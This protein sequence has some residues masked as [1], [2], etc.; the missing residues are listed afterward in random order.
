MLGRR[1][2]YRGS[3]NGAVALVRTADA[4]PWSEDDAALL[5]AVADQLGIALRQIADQRTLERLSRTDDLSG[6]LNR[7]AF[8]EDL[9]QAL[10]RA[11]RERTGGALLYVDLDNFKPIND[12]FGHARGDA[13]L[14]AVAKALRASCRAYDLAARL[15]GDEFAV[16]LGGVDAAGARRRATELLAR[17][18]DLASDAHCED[19]PLSLSI[20]V[21]TVAPGTDETAEQLIRR[22]DAAMYVGK[23]AGKNRYAEAAV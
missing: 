9:A 5:D 11:R 8:G 4:A 17:T 16:W 2:D 10:A 7:R 3:A 15:G 20:G 6:L 22:A 21:A 13:V 18:T 1:T 14:R 12:R 19:A 23:R